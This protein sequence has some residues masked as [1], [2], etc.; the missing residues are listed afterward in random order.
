MHCDEP[1]DVESTRGDRMDNFILNLTTTIYFGKNQ[2]EH[3]GPAVTLYGSKVLVLTGKGSAKKYGIFDEVTSQ[4]DERHIPWVE[5]SGITPNPRLKEILKGIEI[6][7]AEGVDF[8]LAV[9]G[10][11][12]IDAAKAMAFGG[13]VDDVWE[14]YLKGADIQEAL[15]IGVILTLSATGSE[16]NG[17]S[18]ITNERLKQKIPIHSPRLKPAF[19]ILD[20]QYTVS[21][22]R[23]QTAY[24]IADIFSH[25]LEQYF[26]PTSDFWVPDRIAEGL[27]KTL[28]YWGP[29]AYENPK[30][31]EARANLMWA[32]TMALNEIIATG[33]TTDWA[34]HHLEHELSAY[35]DIPHGQ[36]L[37]ILHPYWLEYVLDEPT[38]HRFTMYG[39]N[40]WGLHG[41]PGKVAKA[42]I[43]ETRKFFDSLGLPST[44]SSVGISDEYLEEMADNIV[45]RSKTIGRFKVLHKEDIVKI[46]EMAL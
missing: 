16:M 40:V 13:Y 17:N 5:Y 22:P 25:I 38:L 8:I 28:I 10:G 14:Y 3:L 29:V 18:V 26:S 41:D 31:Y 32:S 11:S 20:P 23:D 30:N 6:I 24:G 7:K 42:S 39:E 2:I 15:P 46:Y 1:K 44:F 27:M 33:K 43:R 12:V 21:V 36:G 9:G 4:L 34:S 35:Y 19:A 45:K 37:A